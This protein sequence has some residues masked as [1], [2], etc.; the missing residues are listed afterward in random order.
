MR[1]LRRDD[2]PVAGAQLSPA[3]G[4]MP[5][6]VRFLSVALALWALAVLGAA[7]RLAAAEAGGVVTGRVIDLSTGSGVA[8]AEVS[9]GGVTA[10]SDLEG[11]FRLAG[12]P[13]GFHEVRATKG[14]YQAGSVSG[15][16]VLAGA[17]AT[18]EVPLKPVGADSVVRLEAFR[19][20]RRWCRRLGSGS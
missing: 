4:R 13:G 15:V 9:L 1:N 20:P 7:S 5:R 10:T 6:F 18:T 3:D 17:V 11:A 19:S 14:G 12:I 16:A 8:G 2:I